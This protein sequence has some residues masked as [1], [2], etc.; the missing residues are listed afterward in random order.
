MPRDPLAWLPLLR[1]WTHCL[2]EGPEAIPRMGVWLPCRSST[3]RP[4]CRVGRGGAMCSAACGTSQ[5]R[6]QLVAQDSAETPLIT[7]LIQM[8]NHWTITL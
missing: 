1:H 2:G 4:C 3:W 6:C 5:R 8:H 7:V